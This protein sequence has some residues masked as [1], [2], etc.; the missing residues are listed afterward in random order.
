MGSGQS[1]GRKSQKKKT[2][3]RGLANVQQGLF[4]GRLMARQK[5]L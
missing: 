4:M 3:R 5:R 2:G 1:L